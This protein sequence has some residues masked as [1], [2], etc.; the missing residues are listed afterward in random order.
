METRIYRYCDEVDSWLHSFTNVD[1]V[2]KQPQKPAPR[3]TT[4][5]F[6]IVC[7]VNIPN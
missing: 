1:T 2:V 4:I 3:P 5:E 7:S 6:A